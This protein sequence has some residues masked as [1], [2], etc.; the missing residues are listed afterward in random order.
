VIENAALF[1]L[2][3]LGI[4]GFAL[5]RGHTGQMAQ[6]KQ[7]AKRRLSRYRLCQIGDRAAEMPSLLG[8]T[9]PRQNRARAYR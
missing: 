7:R 3:M 9:L 6:V 2:L 5:K 4:W 8:E 1:G